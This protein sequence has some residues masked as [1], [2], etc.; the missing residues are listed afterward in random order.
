[1]CSSLR[2][3]HQDWYLFFPGH[4]YHLPDGIDGPKGIGDVH[5]RYEFSSIAQEILIGL[6]VNSA[7]IVDGGNFENRAC[8]LSE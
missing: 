6:D 3:I 2:P 4:G 7:I 8:L 1:M 5:K